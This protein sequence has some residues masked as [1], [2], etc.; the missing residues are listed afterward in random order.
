MAWPCKRKAPDRLWVE[1][2]PEG[3]S[4]IRRLALKYPY[5]CP[6]LGSD[7]TAML[8][9]GQLALAQVQYRLGNFQ[10][11]A[12]IYTALLRDR[13][14]SAPLLRGLGL[15]LAR[16]EKYDEAYKHLRTAHAEEDPKQSITA[17]HLA[18]CAALGKPIQPEDK[19]KNV[20]WAVQQLA[21]FERQGGGRV[22]R[23][24]Q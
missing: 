23:L 9:Q 13:P 8:R 19:A 16:L 21:Q 18:L 1:T 5:Q 2:L 14:P 22:G 4:F 10:E 17:G 12:D 6:V 11:C 3:R 15:A 24:E 7:L 20:A